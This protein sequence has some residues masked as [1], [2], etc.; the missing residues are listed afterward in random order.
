MAGGIFIDQ[1][2]SPNPKCIIFGLAL[3]L[4]YWFVPKKNPFL[5]PVIFVLGYIAMAWYDYM[6]DCRSRLYT[7]SSLVGVGTLDSWAKPQ[8]RDD[9]PREKPPGTLTK[10]QE[11][12]YKRK[13]YAFHVLVVAPL[14]LYV[15]WFG[16]RANPHIWAVIGSLGLLALLYHGGRVFYPRQTTSCQDGTAKAERENLLAIYI[17]HV[18]VVV[19]LLLYVAWRG[20]KADPRVWTTFLTLGI[21]VLAYHSFR[22]FRPRL[23]KQCEKKLIG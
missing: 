11:L 12:A 8:H 20:M 5:L 19:P 2:F 4:S 6:Y 3:C 13:V 15:G 9:V 23:V 21:V 7:G 22:L 18:V 10:D 1:P 16:T 14:F 17:L